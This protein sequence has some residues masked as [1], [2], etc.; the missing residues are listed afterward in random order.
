MNLI[1]PPEPSGYD[2]PDGAAMNAKLFCDGSK[3]DARILSADRPNLGNFRF[4]QLR[5]RMLRTSKPSAA[6][7]CHFISR[8]VLTGTYGKMG[9]IDARWRVAAMHYLHSRWDRAICTLIRNSM[10]C[11]LAAVC[12]YHTVSA[13]VFSPDPKPARIRI[14]ATPRFA[15]HAF[16]KAAF[17]A[18]AV[19]KRVRTH[20]VH[21]PTKAGTMQCI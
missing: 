14:G 2:A 19:S 18:C 16:F 10:R 8:V 21:N 9:W 12:M 4:G 1:L 6:P 7:L 15:S 3:S 20:A 11:F 13:S 5:S 17:V